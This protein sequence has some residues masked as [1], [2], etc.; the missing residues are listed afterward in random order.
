MS[1]YLDDDDASRIAFTGDGWFRTGDLGKLDSE[2]F[3]FLTG[4]IKEIINRGGSKIIPQELD[5]ILLEHPEVAD[6][7]VFAVPHRTLGEEIAA[8]VVPRS[9]GAS[10]FGA[11]IARFRIPARSCL[12]SPA[13]YF[14]CAG[15]APGRHRQGPARKALR[16]VS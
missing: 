5:R 4:R 11:R 8:A 7:A 2:G 13:P 12:Q 9:A 16:A 10:R 3:L 15:T 14:H 1:G 6:A